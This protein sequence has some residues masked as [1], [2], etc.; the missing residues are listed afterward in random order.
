[1][2][3]K[4]RI[5]ARFS[6]EA[7][8]GPLYLPDLTL[9]YRHH[10]SRNTLP[11]E[12]KNHS[13]P[14]I[15]KSLAMPT[16][17]VT[18][19]WKLETPGMQTIEQDGKRETRFETSAGVLTAN[20]TLGADGTWWQIEY[21]VKTAEDLEAAL[22]VVRS[23]SYTLDTTKLEGLEAAVGDEGVLVIEIPTRPYMDLLY[24]FLGLSEGFMLLSEDHPSVREIIEILETKLQ[25]FIQEI[26][27]LPGS[28]VFSHDNLD[29]QFISPMVFQKFLS[30]SYRLTAEVLHAHDKYLLVH[31]GGPI[32]PLLAPLAETGVD[33]IEGIS[34]PPQSDVSLSQAREISG[35]TFTLWGGI[36][37]DFLLAAHDEEAFET[38]VIQAAQEAQADGRMILGVADQVPADVDLSR[39]KAIS[40][41][42]EQTRV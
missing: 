2:T 5:L 36:P 33:G 7:S 4:K 25:Q 18:R 6:G 30:N 16:W 38:S 29:G 26:A 9:W 10:Q 15:T 20:W 42:V 12:W 28:I 41:L 27:S 37:Q 19:P 39:L 22:E 17:L 3:D 31:T 32:R 34:G 14:E 35:S 1:M 13:L 40:S 24:G 23:R 21:P 8:E 11:E